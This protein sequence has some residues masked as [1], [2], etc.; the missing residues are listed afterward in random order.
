MPDKKYVY[1]FADG[2]AEGRG[3]WRNLLGGKG[4]GLAEMTALGIRVPPGFTL[5]T[6]AGLAY[7]ALG[8]RY[9]DGLWDEVL[10]A[11]GSV[12]RSLG[13]TFDDP[14]NPLLLS[15]R[16]GARESMPGM[17]DTVLNI[18]LNDQ[19]VEGLAIEAGGLRFAYDSYRR[20]VTMFS[21]V[22][23]GVP[24]EV[25]EALLS[26]AK[27][28]HQVAGDSALGPE[29]LRDLIAVMKARVQDITGRAFP[30]KPWDQLRLSINAVLASWHNDRAVAYRRLHGIPDDWGT[31]VNVQ[32]MVF[33]NRG[34]DSGTGVVFTRDPSSG[35]KYLFGEFLSNAQ[36]E[37]VVAGI[38]DPKPLTTLRHRFPTVHDELAQVCQRLELHYR[39][40]QDIEFTVQNGVLYLLQTRSGK[41]TAPAAVRIAVEMVQEGL[42]DSREAVMRVHPAQIDQLLHPMIDPQASLKVLGRGLPASP[43]AASGQAVFTAEDA[44]RRQENGARVLLIR[45]ETS[46][47]DI[48]GMHAAQGIL[49]A[50]G[51]M[52]SHAAVVARGMGKCCVVGCR[53]SVDQRE[54]RLLPPRKSD[55]PGWRG[56]NPG[57]HDGPDYSGA[58]PP[59]RSGPRG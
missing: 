46:P 47:E 58:G 24:H 12:E 49:T 16:S 48:R 41:R 20:F 2:V 55:D 42:I 6:E 37:D 39:D 50:R 28:Q 31:A 9:P 26:E 52:T 35:E 7:Y 54:C 19:T 45:N 27:A 3:E 36:G 57:R 51:G 43:G 38:R 10:T 8:N 29:A 44:V 5:S 30:N 11:L 22:V 34:E 15:V 25:L 21:N 23:M 53:E 32:A 13:A 17:M 56:I 18:G 33:G 59:R 1:L 14:N 4:A 40:M